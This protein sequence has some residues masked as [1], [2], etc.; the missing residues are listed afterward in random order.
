M[1]LK[2]GTYFGLSLFFTL[3]CK[4]R[5]Y[6][7]DSFEGGSRTNAFV[8]GLD[9]IP[10]FDVNDPHSSLTKCKLLCNAAGIAPQER[11]KSLFRTPQ[12]YGKRIVLLR[13]SSPA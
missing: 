8:S 10:L 4:S 5:T 7:N 9:S 13:N 12:V 11:L 3:S 1:R 2:S 6:K